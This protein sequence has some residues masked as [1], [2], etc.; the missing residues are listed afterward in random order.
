MD[1]LLPPY[2]RWSSQRWV[3]CRQQ[4]HRAVR[5][6]YSLSLA[7]HGGLEDKATGDSAAAAV[8]EVDVPVLGM[9]LST[10]PTYCL[11]SLSII[12]CFEN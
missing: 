1:L 4:R 11:L 8:G 6:L 5:W 10:A 2:V 3:V 12:Y 9:M 7:Y